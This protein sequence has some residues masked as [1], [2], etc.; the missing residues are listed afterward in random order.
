MC[1]TG[2]VVFAFGAAEGQERWLP[3]HVPGTWE[4]SGI[5][6]LANYDGVAWYRCFVKVSQEWQGSRVSFW[7]GAADDSA[8][9]FVNGTQITEA[10]YSSSAKALS[11]IV[12]QDALR[13]GDWNLIAVRVL[14]RR[15][16]GGIVGAGPALL[17]EKGAVLLGGN[18]QFRTGDDAAWAQWPV[19]P[20]SEEGRAMAESAAQVFGAGPGSEGVTFA[21]EADPPEGGLAL[22]YRK[23][24]WCWEEALPVGNGRMGAMVFG[25]LVEERIQLNEETL[26]DGYERDTTNPKALEALPKVRKLLFEGKNKAA[27]KLAGE[28]MMGIPERINSYQTLAD[29]KLAF[30]KIE[31]AKGYLRVLDLDSGIAS[32]Q[33]AVGD[34]KFRREVFASHPDQVIVVMMEADRPGALSFDA[35]LTRQQDAE[36]VSEGPDTL[37]LK[38]QIH[39]ENEETKQIAGLRFETHVRAIPS[40]GSIT[41][42]NGVLSVQGADRVVLLITGATTYKGRDPYA[43]CGEILAKAAP[44]AY[45]D[46]RSAHVKDHQSLFQRVHL[47]LGTPPQTKLPTDERLA[48]IRG[49]M[50]DNAFA[51]L[52]F[53]YGRYLLMASSRPGDL[54]ANL[55]GVWNEHIDAPWNSD[56]HTNI[57]LQMNYWIAEVGNLGECHLP[58]FDYM[59]S[60]VP[61]GEHTAQVHYGARGWVVH[62]LSNIYGVTTPADGIWGIWPMGAAWLCQHPYEHYLYTQDREFLETR[63]YPL[64]KGAAQFI[65]DFLVPDAKNQLVTNPS[66]SPENSFRKR[67]GTISMFTYAATMDLEIIH[68][69]FANTIEASKTLETDAEFREELESALA[70]L[71]PLQVSLKTGRLQEWIEDYDEPEPGHRHMSHLYALHPGHQITIR[72]TPKLAA[73]ARRSLEYRLEHGGGHTGWSRAWIIS[74]WARFEEPEKAYENVKALFA[75]C[76]LNNL[77]DTHPPFQIDGNFGGA[78]G[79]AEMLLQSHAGEVSLLPALPGAWQNGSVSGLCARGGYEVDMTWQEGALVSA[80][81]RSQKGGKCRVRSLWPLEVKVAGEAVGIERP[82]QNVILFEARKGQQY[83]L[84]VKPR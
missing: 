64:M 7:L 23:P 31:Q 65:L 71:A 9:M 42:A 68:D 75:K 73:A 16:T 62:H 39:R 18:W 50:E 52:Y 5:E 63:A 66:H 4:S 38:G 8:T 51:T 33:Y 34:V 24:A 67:D 74:F 53:Q 28:T 36:C 40:G 47:D 48:L 46:L 22:W 80:A 6:E 21:G 37:V 25:N 41:N 10:D 59:D 45:D 57:N 27:E 26:W 12:P 60:L 81:I 77:F 58:L 14:D 49:G 83:D 44:K 19:D 1:L 70:R 79:I 56:Y 30:P 20:A 29:L 15:Q 35:K 3:V 69:L 82:D 11:Y 55:Q 43:F 61:S 76:T 2:L 17:S 78:A 13:F 72:E 54:P 32:T 84:S